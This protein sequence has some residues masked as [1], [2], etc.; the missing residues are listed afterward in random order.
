VFAALAVFTVVELA[1][2]SLLGELRPLMIVLLMVVA[3]LKAALVALYYMHLKFEQVALGALA[4]APLILVA[5]LILF[6]MSDVSFVDQAGWTFTPS[7]ASHAEAAA[8]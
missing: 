3:V 5:V 8:H 7:D 4:A 1:I 2:P 6:I